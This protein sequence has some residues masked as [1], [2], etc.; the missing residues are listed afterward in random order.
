MVIPRLKAWIKKVV[1]EEKESEEDIL[2]SKLAEEASEAAKAAAASAA[3]VAKASQELIDSKNEGLLIY[4]YF[5]YFTHCF[6]LSS[7]IFFFFH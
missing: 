4:S 7:L 3:V 6:L 5:K 1:E 2:S